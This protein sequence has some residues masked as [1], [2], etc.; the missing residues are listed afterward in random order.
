MKKVWKIA[1]P[2]PH[3]SKSLSQ[4]LKTLP[5]FAQVLINRGFKDEEK[6]R[7]FLRAKLSQ[8]HSPYLLRDMERAITLIEKTVSKKGPIL[9]Y[10]DY[11]VDGVTATALLYQ[12]LGVVGAEVSFYIPH[13]LEEGYGLN[14]AAIKEAVDSGIK[15]IITCD[16][17]TNDW[18]VLNFAKSLDVDII[19]TD[20]HAPHIE[21]FP[22]FPLINPKRKDSNYPYLDLA[23]VGVAFKLVQALLERF[24]FSERVRWE[25][26]HLDLV[27]LGTI[28]DAV[29]FT[30]E[31]RIIVKHGLKRLARS[32]NPG[33][34][35]LKEVAGLKS[36]VFLDLDSRKVGFILAPRINAA[37]RL[38]NGALG[39]KLLTARSSL[40]AASLAKTMDELNRKR[41]NIQELIFKEALDKI[42]REIDLEKEKVILLSSEKWHLGVIGIVAS[43][44]VDRFSRP[45][46][47]LSL[48]KVIRG[49]ARSVEGF[50]LHEVL[51][52]CQEHLINFGGHKYAA[53]LTISH[54]QIPLFHRRLKE[55]G[56]K[57]I[58][59]ESFAGQMEVDGEVSL[60]Q[61][62]PLLLNHL[63]YLA[64][65]GP[66]NPPP[67]FLSR[68]LQLENFPRIVGKR[69]LKFMVREKNHLREV[70]GFGFGE[71]LP[72]LLPIDRKVNI[73]Y[74][75]EINQWQGEAFIQLN[76]K[77]MKVVGNTD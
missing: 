41:Q 51:A 40:E 34:Q 26:E 18:S 14:E 61:I 64:P 75:P 59:Q 45:V 31:N 60:E 63:Q 23:G 49:S 32:T 76:L 12:A 70:I 9:I 27:A 57:L 5:L 58:P 71:R 11:D 42:N 46:V 7:L 36:D 3:L 47:L 25:I 33:I 1:C 29:P 15:L 50:P 53:G 39:V 21:P 73:V 67:T 74:S 2:N 13:R 68:M 37:G 38:E 16:C 55:L 72:Q 65:F 48:N 17:G 52:E 43:R 44:L 22:E 28:A 66:G 30:G 69:H 4:A 24:D 56:E 6:A 35:A 77:D 54:D 8:M 20:H 10:G 19:I 62:T